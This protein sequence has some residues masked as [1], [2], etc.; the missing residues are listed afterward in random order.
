MTTVELTTGDGGQNVVRVENESG[1]GEVYIHGATLTAWQPAGEEPV[2]WLSDGAVFD[3]R[4]AIRGGVPIC[5]P[6]FGPGRQGDKSPAHGFVRI[7]DWT[8]HEGQ[9]ESD[10]SGTRLTF[11]LTDGDV[12]FQYDVSLGAELALSLTITAGAEPYD[13]EEALHAYLSVGDVREIQVLGLEGVEYVDKTAD[14]AQRVQEGPITFSGETDRVY[15]AAP[16]VLVNDPVLGRRLQV[17]STG[18]ANTVVW[19][20]WADKAASLP[21]FPDDAWPTMVC[22]ESGNVLNDAFTLEPGQSHTLTQIIRVL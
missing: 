8:W 6:W 3:G 16:E 21:D 10:E 7:Q 12:R 14:Q 22:V 9:A 15:L 19:N 17:F 18:A 4:T 11:T 13:V 1:Q 20:P 2:V 5:A